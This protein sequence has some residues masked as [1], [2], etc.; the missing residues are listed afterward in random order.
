MSARPHISD[1]VENNVNNIYFLPN[2]TIL[3]ICGKMS[4]YHL[5]CFSKKYA[6]DCTESVLSV[7]LNK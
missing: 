4:E 7:S 6:Q 3:C 5:I 1:Y 2:D